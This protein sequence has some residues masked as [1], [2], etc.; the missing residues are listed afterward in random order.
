MG[1][2]EPLQ[3]V[4]G[5]ALESRVGMG[6]AEEGNGEG[7]GQESRGVE[8]CAKEKGLKDNRYRL[9]TGKGT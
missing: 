9:Q 7:D 2:G 6:V 8:F 3:V 4:K 1:G 5:E